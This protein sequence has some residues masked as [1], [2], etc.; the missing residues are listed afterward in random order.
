MGVS[1]WAVKTGMV[2]FCLCFIIGFIR[3]IRFYTPMILKLWGI[4]NKVNKWGY[5]KMREMKGEL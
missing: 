5:D 1:D 4:Y 2:V 3:S